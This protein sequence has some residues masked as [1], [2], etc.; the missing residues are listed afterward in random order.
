MACVNL[1]DGVFQNSFT[2]FFY[3]VF[4]SCHTIDKR[5]I[6]KVEAAEDGCN[7]LTWKVLKNGIKHIQNAMM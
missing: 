3:I 6:D 7:R 5:Q 4:V 1:V 2:E